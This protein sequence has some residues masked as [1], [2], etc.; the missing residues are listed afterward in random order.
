LSVE[1]LFFTIWQIF[2]ATRFLPSIG[3]TNRP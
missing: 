3:L 1:G 2:C